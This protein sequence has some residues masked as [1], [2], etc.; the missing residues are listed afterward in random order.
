M[1]FNQTMKCSTSFVKI[2]SKEASQMA[3]ATLKWVNEMRASRKAKA[4]EK[5]RQRINNGFWHKLFRLKEATIEDAIAN[6]AYDNWNFD[7]HWNECIGAENETVAK[8]I[9]NASKHAEGI[10][11]SI[12]EL[13]LIS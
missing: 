12:E 4:I 5:E 9:L 13:H 8:R 1:I 11:I 3:E 6:L 10:M 2:N 7:Y